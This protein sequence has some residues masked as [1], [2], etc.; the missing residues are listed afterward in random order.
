MSSGGARHGIIVDRRA[1]GGG[2]S[3]AVGF[4]VVQDEEDGRYYGFDYRQIVT[5]GFRTIRTGERVRF[6]VSAESVDRAEFVIRLDQPDP[7]EYYR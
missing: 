2:L 3:G 7:A 1:S 5:E 6:Q 4:Y